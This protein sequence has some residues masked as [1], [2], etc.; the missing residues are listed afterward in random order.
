MEE[1]SI[2]HHVNI[3]FFFFSAVAIQDLKMIA[4]C[5]TPYPKHPRGCP[6]WNYK[7]G[8]PPQ[9]KPFL[10]LYL[11]GVRVVIAQ[12]DFGRYLTLKKQRHPD[13]TERALRNPLHWQGH[14]RAKLN[15]YVSS[16]EIPPGFEI[17]DNPE[18]M[19]INIF[20]T[21]HRAD[22]VLERNPTLFVCKIKFL[23]KP[24]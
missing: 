2:L 13:W 15:M 14:L 24:R 7:E 4:F 19:G 11:P 9:T 8:C 1:D 6:N 16:L 3:Q 21:C 23:A 22:F 17:V 18:A 12:M 10:N 5:R 20:E